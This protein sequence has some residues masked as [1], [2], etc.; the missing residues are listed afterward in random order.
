[1]AWIIVHQKNN[2]MEADLRRVAKKSWFV[3]LSLCVKNKKGPPLF[4]FLMCN[5]A[6][7]VRKNNYSCPFCLLLRWRLPIYMVYF[8]CQVTNTKR[9]W[10]WRT[11]STILNVGTKSICK[12]L[13]KAVNSVRW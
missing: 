13:P 1:M 11:R 9:K 5:V 7:N 8:T 2:R 10:R 12:I 6:C 4:I 3:R